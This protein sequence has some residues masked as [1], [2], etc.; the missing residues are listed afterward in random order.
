MVQVTQGVTWQ[1]WLVTQALPLWSG[2]GYDASRRLYHERLTYAAAPILLPELRLMVQ[3]R[4]IATFCRAELDDTFHASEEAL[5][6][7]AEVQKRY[8]RADGAPGWVFSLAPNGTPVQTTRDLYAHAFILFAYAWAYRLTNDV[9][10]LRVAQATVLEVESILAA[11]GGGFVSSMPQPN[12]TRSQNPHMHLLEAYLALFEVTADQFYLDRAQALVS[13]ALDKFICS[14]SGFL[15]EFFTENW[16]PK[17]CFGQN[18]VEPGHLFEWSWLLKEAVRLCPD[19]QQKNAV[20]TVSERLSCRG[21]RYGFVQ[22]SVCDTINESGHITGANSR[23]WPQTELMRLLASKPNK[24][25]E[26]QTVLRK[27]TARFFMFYA[28]QTL[29]GGWIDRVS[30]QGKPMVDH[31]PASSLYH[32]YGAAREFCI[33]P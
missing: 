1:N 29:Q 22:Q 8:W 10:L 3:A 5:L 7:L 11:P 23:I 25:P 6:C 17:E 27:I 18:I 15:L 28:P 32:I 2:A 20:I 31:M 9:G 19:L 12:T 30:E 26:E 14:H 16:K 24:T 21:L 13:L 33:A 4:Q